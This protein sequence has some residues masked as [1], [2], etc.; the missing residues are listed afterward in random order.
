MANK[1]L[2]FIFGAAAVAAVVAVVVTTGKTVAD[3]LTGGRALQGTN[4]VVFTGV[5]NNRSRAATDFAVTAVLY[6][7]DGTTIV[8]AK[9]AFYT[10][11][12]RGQVPV[13]I[14]LGG[15]GPTVK[16]IV[17]TGQPNTPGAVVLQRLTFTVQATSAQL[18]GSLSPV[19][20]IARRADIRSM[21]MLD[22]IQVGT[23]APVYDDLGVITGQYPF[24]DTAA[25]DGQYPF[26]D[27][28]M[29]VGQPPFDDVGLGTYASVRPVGGST[30]RPAPRPAA[31]S[32]AAPRPAA[33][34]PVFRPRA[35]V[36]PVPTPFD[37]RR[38]RPRVRAEFD[39]GQ[40][41]QML[42]D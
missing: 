5:L 21:A 42:G 34:S 9:R 13:S 37:P 36:A 2:L 17:S 3:W 29:Q 10:V 32:P 30:A 11:P 15:I 27:T 4:V 39:M 18:S 24:A 35:P 14:S 20:S 8:D 33:P 6:A 16:V 12:L 19:F 31:P 23:N 25:G 26:D 1:G 28:G 7:A 22:E 38:P 40:A 41:G